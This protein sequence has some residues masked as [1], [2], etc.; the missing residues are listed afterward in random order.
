MAWTRANLPFG[1]ITQET[2]GNG[3]VS[4]I[5]HADP[6]GRITGITSGSLQNLSY[7]WDALG[8]LTSRSDNLSTGNVSE[9]FGYDLLNRLTQAQVTNSSGV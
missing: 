1:Q 2:Y 8:N 3:V 9:S 6:L 5:A 7:A 4:N